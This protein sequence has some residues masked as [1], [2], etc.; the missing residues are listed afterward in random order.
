[1]SVSAVP[2]LKFIL[3]KYSVSELHLQKLFSVQK[4][5]S[6]SVGK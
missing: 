3:T 6:N 1:M 5:N 2:L 4:Q